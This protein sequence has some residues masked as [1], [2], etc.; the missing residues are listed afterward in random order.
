M[1]TAPENISSPK[2]KFVPLGIDKGANG[3]LKEEY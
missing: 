1:G 3:M 2:D